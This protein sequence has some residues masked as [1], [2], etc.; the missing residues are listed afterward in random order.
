MKQ[1]RYAQQCVPVFVVCSAGIGWRQTAQP[2]LAKRDANQLLRKK[3]IRAGLIGAGR[4]TEKS[5]NAHSIL[6]IAA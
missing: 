4:Q 2:V 5:S 3:R 6:R 1:N